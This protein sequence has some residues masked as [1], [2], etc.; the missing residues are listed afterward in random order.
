MGNKTQFL[1]LLATLAGMADAPAIHRCIAGD[2]TT[3][4]QSAPCPPDTR[5]DWVRAIVVEDTPLVVAPVAPTRAAPPR[6][7]PLRRT[8]RRGSGGSDRDRRCAEA[9]RDADATRDRLWNRLGFRERSELDAVVA[10][11]CSR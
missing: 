11:A 10:R 5:Q 1:Y 6:A 2:G 8:S 4:Y 7:L 3:R 9:R